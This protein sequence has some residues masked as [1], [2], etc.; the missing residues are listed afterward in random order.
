MLNETSQL[1][2]EY[3]FH[4]KAQRLGHTMIDD[5]DISIALDFT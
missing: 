3:V 1:R 2:G 4:R 5:Q